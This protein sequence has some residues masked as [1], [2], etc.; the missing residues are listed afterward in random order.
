[1]SIDQVTITIGGD[2][3]P[4]GTESAQDDDVEITAIVQVDY[5]PGGPHC[6]EDFEAYLYRIKEVESTLGGRHKIPYQESLADRV[7][8]WMD[9]NPD[10]VRT[11]CAKQ[12]SKTKRVV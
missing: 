8:S 9:A 11:R 12:R 5:E 3:L 6:P 10:D 1:M 2:E 4:N 7:E